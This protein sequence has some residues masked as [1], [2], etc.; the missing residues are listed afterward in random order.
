MSAVSTG[1]SI[2][3]NSERVAVESLIGS[4][5][6]DAVM[7][8]GL[9]GLSWMDMRGVKFS[10]PFFQQTVERLRT[11]EPTRTERFTE[12]DALIQLEKISDSLRPSGFIF[13][14]SRCGSTLI[15]NACKAVANSIVISEAAA[16]DKL[17]GRFITD[18]AQGGVKE[19]LYSIFLRGVV[20]AL[21]QRRAGDERHF[22]LKFSCCTVAQ[23]AH[24]KRIWP[25]VPWIFMYRDPTETI[26]S[27]LASLPEWLAADSDPRMLAALI[28]TSDN[29][30]RAMSHAELC[31]RAI[32][33][34]YSIAGELADSDCM[35]VNYSQLSVSVLLSMLEFF[36]VTPSPQ[37]IE[38]VTRTSQIYS[39]DVSSER[40]FVADVDAKRSLASP[41][42]SEM[43]ERWASS[44]YQL[45]EQ[46]RRKL[47]AMQ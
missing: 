5:P 45:L 29:E 47:S 46:R 8:N 33:R 24:I 13:H 18:A 44:S 37:E 25:G 27:N 34:F 19:L 3:H 41:L 16:V 12:F 23:L 9:P 4:L 14:S 2:S 28:N 6:V 30:I 11:Q 20:N 36:K 17:A 1:A 32:G 22:F 15:T 21:G 10:E 26:V 40:A 7:A 42:V 35:L 38:G 39:K 43:A 31:A